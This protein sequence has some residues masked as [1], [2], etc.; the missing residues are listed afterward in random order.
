MLPC[1]R[2]DSI[3]DVRAKTFFKVKHFWNIAIGLQLSAKYFVIALWEEE[4]NVNAGCWRR[5]FQS[6]LG[7]CPSLSLTR[8]NSDFIDFIYYIDFIFQLGLF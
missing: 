1:P 5:V 4:Y 7:A 2:D 3:V 6:F 8:I